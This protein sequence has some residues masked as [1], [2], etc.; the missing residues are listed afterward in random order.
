MTMPDF[1]PWPVPPNQTGM[2]RW[3]NGQLCEWDDAPAVEFGQIWVPVCIW[4]HR[5]P[6][7]AGSGLTCGGLLGLTCIYPG[8]L[9]L[10]H[11]G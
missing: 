1:N 5:G 2:V 7:D 6:L 11:T 10:N 9:A 8:D 3:I 4:C